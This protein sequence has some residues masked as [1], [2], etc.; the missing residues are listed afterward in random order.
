[1]PV[2]IRNFKFKLK[3]SLATVPS[4]SRDFWAQTLNKFWTKERKEILNNIL[5]F[6]ASSMKHEDFLNYS[7]HFLRNYHHYCCWNIVFQNLDE[8][9]DHQARTQPF[10][11]ELVYWLGAL[12]SLY[13]NGLV[14][15]IFN[16]YQD[17][18]R[19]Q[20]G[21]PCDGESHAE[22]VLMT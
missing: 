11:S 18:L 12:Y 6:I 5:D 13:W 3:K 2:S 14:H 22:W 7:D 19:Q 9:A 8:K 17:V 20:L 1:M 16:I 10:K 21:K 15:H 4:V